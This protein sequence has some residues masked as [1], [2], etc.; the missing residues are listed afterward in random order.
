ME[1]KQNDHMLWGE[2]EQ[3]VKRVE[4]DREPTGK[5]KPYIDQIKSILLNHNNANS[6]GVE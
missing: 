4:E 1:N 6:T 3:F 2:L 5:A